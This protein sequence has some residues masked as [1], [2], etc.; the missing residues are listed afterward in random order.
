MQTK[1]DDRTDKPILKSQSTKA[2]THDLIKV[3]RKKPLPVRLPLTSLQLIKQVRIDVIKHT[4]EN[5]ISENRQKA[6]KLLNEY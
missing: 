1:V 5:R 4:I 2:K 3:L 6:Q